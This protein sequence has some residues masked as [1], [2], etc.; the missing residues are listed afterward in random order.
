MKL[1]PLSKSKLFDVGL[2]TI[3][4]C[5]STNETICEIFK[6]SSILDLL[7]NII[8]MIITFLTYFVAFRENR[9]DM[10]FDPGRDEQ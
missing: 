5:R 3:L 7:Y 9:I 10:K 2:H 6:G 4:K 8:N 1:L